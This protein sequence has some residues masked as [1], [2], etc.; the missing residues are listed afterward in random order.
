MEHDT[1]I[2]VRTVAGADA[3]RH[4]DDV[5]A[6]RIAVFR[7]WPYLYAGDM[8][9]ERDYLAAYAASPRSVFVL[10]CDG[11][12]VVGASTGI[13]LRDDA[14]A[15]HEPFRARGLDAGAVFYFGESVLLP[16]F[17]GRGVGHAFF[18]AREAHAR[19]LG[20]FGW[21]A[22]AAVDRDPDD[23]RRP[24]GS[25]GN[26]GFWTRRG[27]ARQPGLTMRLRWDELELGERMHDLT[28]WTRRLEDAA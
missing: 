8:G 2:T 28:F 19:A 11:D 14:A 1:G 10:A 9:Y 3:R 23:A 7:E 20:G 6:L 24:P 13:P 5:A 18:D 27:Y 15:F 17:R 21:T 12:R 25:R 16:A 22:F 26:D 4:L